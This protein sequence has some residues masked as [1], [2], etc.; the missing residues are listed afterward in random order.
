M[1]NTKRREN[2]N[3]SLYQCLKKTKKF[4]KMKEKINIDEG[5]KKTIEYYRSSYEKQK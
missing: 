5:L 3:I 1:R 4:I 2:E